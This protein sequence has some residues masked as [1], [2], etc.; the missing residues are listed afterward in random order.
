MKNRLAVIAIFK[1]NHKD[2]QGLLE[3]MDE[4]YEY[5]ISKHE[6]IQIHGKKTVMTVIMEA[7]ETVVS[8]FAGKIGLLRGTQCQVIYEKLPKKY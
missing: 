8:T 7:P 5:L 1:E 4:Y 3:L 2:E 6:V